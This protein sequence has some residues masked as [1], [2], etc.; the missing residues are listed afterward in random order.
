MKFTPAIDILENATEQREKL[1]V[2]LFDAET[3]AGQISSASSNGF[4]HLRIAQ[5]QPIDLQYTKYARHLTK[6]LLKAGFKVEWL[7]SSM[8]ELSGKRKTEASLVFNELSIS[9]G[10]IR[11][12][13]GEQATLGA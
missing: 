13:G 10:E 1:A 4:Y 12:S 9:W 7:K 8:W 2:Q 5:E 3:V 6:A 11:R